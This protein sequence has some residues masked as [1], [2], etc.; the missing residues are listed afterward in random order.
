MLNVNKL[1]L[2]AARRVVLEYKDSNKRL[3]DEYK[4]AYTNIKLAVNNGYFLESFWY[5]NHDRSLTLCFTNEN[6]KPIILIFNEYTQKIVAETFRA[7]YQHA[8]DLNNLCFG[9]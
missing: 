1:A 7:A 6:E 4:E 2:T 9:E 8:K 3:F 5:N